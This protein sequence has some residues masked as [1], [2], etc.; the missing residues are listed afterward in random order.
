MM[1]PF[2]IHSKP[3]YLQV[4]VPMVLGIREPWGGAECAGSAL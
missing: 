3:C 4:I 2:P 1:R